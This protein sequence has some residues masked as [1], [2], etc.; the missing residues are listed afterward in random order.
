M[1]DTGIQAE[2]DEAKKNLEIQRHLRELSES[3]NEELKK[4]VR[5]R[6]SFVYNV[7]ICKKV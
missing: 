7:Y 5:R 3:E 6:L 1:E 4:Q 2:L